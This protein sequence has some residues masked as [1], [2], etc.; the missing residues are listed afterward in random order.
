LPLLN[1]IVSFGDIAAEDDSVLLEYFLST[2]AVRQIE[3]GKYIL[4]IGR[5]G[6]GKTALVRHFTETG[7]RSHGKP[8]SLRSYPWTAHENLVDKGASTTEAYVASWKLLISIRLAS[9]VCNLGQNLYT[10]SISALEKFL[11]KNYG[12]IDPDTGTILAKENLSVEGLT[13]AP[14]IAGITLGSITFGDQSRH[15]MLGLELNSLTES[16][17]KDVTIAISELNIESLFLHFDELDQGLDKLDES[18]S[19][20]LTGLILAAR[21]ISRSRNLRANISPIVYLRSDIWDQLDFSDKNKITQSST[22]NLEWS[23]DSL[24]QLSELRLKR[25]LGADASWSSVDDGLKMRGSQAKW[26]HIVSR[27]LLRPRDVIQFLNE[28]LIL[29][30]RRGQRILTFANEDINGARELYSNYLKLELDDEILPHWTFWH[31]ALQ[32]CSRTQT[33]TFTKDDFVTNY[34]KVKSSVNTLDAERALEALYKFS[35]IGYEKRFAKGGSSWSFRYTDNASGWDSSAPRFK[36]HLGL[37]EFAKL[38]E[39]RAQ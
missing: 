6:S 14:S 15:K 37:K 2:D 33:I 25:H 24:L 23:D 12:S 31:E 29:A 34:R 19:R 27:T 36:V 28:A 17:L 8:L 4:V 22:I 3:T 35:V 39:E 26:A 16:I 11:V 32:A 5:K 18:K 20:M 9:M 13:I 1:D 21:E 10:D 7:K 30:K 38:K